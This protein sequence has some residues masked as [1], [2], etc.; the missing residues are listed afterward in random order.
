L[1]DS[2]FEEAEAAFTSGDLDRAEAL[3]KALLQ[4]S[5]FLGS[6]CHLLGAIALRRRAPDQALHW[7]ERAI[8]SGMVNTMTLSNCGEAFR[9]LGRL[10]DAYKRFEQALQVDNTNSTAHFNL[11]LVMRSWGHAKESEHF[12]RTALSLTPKMARAHNELAE[13]YRQEGHWQEAEV[14]YKQALEVV[15]EQDG[16]DER[17]RFSQ[18]SIRLASLLRERGRPLQSVQLLDETLRNVDD[19]AAHYEMAKAKFDLCWERE[20]LSHYLRARLLQPSICLHEHGRSVSARLA[21]IKDWCESGNGRYTLLARSHFL[22]LPPLRSIPNSARESFVLGSPVTAELGFA[23]A[24]DAEVLPVDFSVLAG[25]YVLV[26]GVINWFQHYARRGQLVRH[27]TDDGRV[28]LDLPRQGPKYDGACVLLG[29]ADTQY[30]WLYECLARLWVVEQVPDLAELPLV[31][32][33]DLTAD[34]L[35]MLTYFDVPEKRLLRLGEDQSLQVRELHIPSLPTVGDW[36]S[37][38][39]LQFLRR[40]LRNGHPPNWRRRYFLSRDGLPDRR[41]SNESD[42]MAILNEYDFEVIKISEKSPLE[43][44]DLLCVAQCVVGIDDDSMANLLV[45]PQGARIGIIATAGTYR[46]RAYFVCGQLAQEL[47]YLVGETVYES[48]SVHSLCDIQLPEA[49]LRRF[50]GELDGPAT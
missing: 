15:A 29:K 42:L 35:A 5:A 22:A 36:I 38:L 20:A 11:G 43:L 1:A 41:L 17:T 4:E 40:R 7:I 28:L 10:D 33:S 46:P 34:R 44:I 31:V 47:T 16:S 32:S 39:A 48:N 25:G 6:A 26:G 27:E 37:P 50:L 8:K 19:A 3:S 21:S 2:L 18:W 24:L 45:C 12:F 9:Q 13:L 14:E 49:T 23:T 30:E